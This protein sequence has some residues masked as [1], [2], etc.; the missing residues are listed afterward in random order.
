MG[1][2]KQEWLETQE[3]GWTEPEGYVCT[4][5]VEDEFLKEVIRYH[6]CQRKCDYCGNR[7]RAFS[8]AP[9]SA[10]M[11]V[12][13]NTVFYYFN[14]P[15]SSG[16]P[17]ELMGEPTDTHDVLME[18][19]LECNDQLFE[20]LA[21]AFV[22]DAWVRAAGGHWASSHEHE[23]LSYS[24]D[25]FVCLVKHEKR[26]F[27]I[28]DSDSDSY[29]SEKYEPS[30]LLP[31]I[32]GIVNGLGLIKQLSGDATLFRVRE[33]NPGDTWELDANQMGAPPA[34]LARAGR[35]NPA[36]ISYLY[37]ALERQTALAEVLQSPPCGAA[38]ATF[39]SQEMLSVLDLT[40]LPELSSIFDHTANEERESL[41]F[42]RQFV[43][44]ISKPV[45]KDGQ[46]HFE[47]VP[48]QIVSEYFALIFRHSGEHHLDGIMYPSAV[49]PGGKNLVLFPSK[50]GYE[51][52][53]DQVVFQS[54]MEVSFPNW[55][56][57]TGA[58]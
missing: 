55:Y 2:A 45:R 27:F 30:R 14:E 44:E 28:E 15:A 34:E 47:Y 51:R 21:N 7:T 56:E 24:W 6:A 11:E 41:L 40:A 9:V 54:A 43:K 37:L 3:R 4:Q 22:N 20:D 49:R 26:F 16:I 17:W 5:C 48:S 57:F 31:V 13:S 53:F 39:F 19:G 58:I 8:A 33:R 36:G 10:L 38:L 35:M 25:S 29:E 52:N 50:R 1:R 12:I 18:L 42:L 46:E 32:G 23:I